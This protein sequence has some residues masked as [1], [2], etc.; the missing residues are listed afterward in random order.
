MYAI[1]VPW[2]F[3]SWLID[4]FLFQDDDPSETLPDVAALDAMIAAAEEAVAKAEGSSE[5]RKA[6]ERKE[7]LMRLKRVEQ[8]Y[9]RP[10]T[11][12]IASVR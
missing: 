1:F 2:L 6:K 7:D 8:L 10:P 12:P 11:L 5:K 9:V 3:V 4:T